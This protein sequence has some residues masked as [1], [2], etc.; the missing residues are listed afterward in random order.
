MASVDIIIPAERGM[1]YETL[2]AV[3]AMARHAIEAK[4]SVR[5]MPTGTG[6]G[7]IHLSRNVMIALALY[8]FPANPPADYFFLCDDDMVNKPGDLTRLLS[9]KAQ[10]KIIT[11]I[12]T[13][14][15]DP[16]LPTIRTWNEK[17]QKYDEI[18]KWDFDSN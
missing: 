10:K 5:I 3:Q 4:H 16:P 13:K 17:A 12:A 1:E 18:Q 6:N 7:I 11:G 2:N 8:G 14:R 15:K 9:Y